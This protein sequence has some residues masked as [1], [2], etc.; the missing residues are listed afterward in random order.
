MAFDTTELLRYEKA[1][2]LRSL[3]SAARVKSRSIVINFR[4]PGHLLASLLMTSMLFVI[5]R[6]GLKRK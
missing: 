2:S 6:P 4:I 1:H 5:P 3:V